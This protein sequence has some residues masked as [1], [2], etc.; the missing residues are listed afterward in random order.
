MCERT[1]ANTNHL[2]LSDATASQLSL[3]EICGAKQALLL[4]PILSSKRGFCISILRCSY[5]HL[6]EKS[7]HQLR[8]NCVHVGFLKTKTAQNEAATPESATLTTDYISS[9]ALE[10]MFAAWQPHTMNICD[11]AA[12]QLDC[13]H[14]LLKVVIVSLQGYHDCPVVKA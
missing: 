5:A 7:Q 11:L 4:K 2:P 1:T 14:L 9:F 10:G 6:T 3:F 8:S 13:L 12:M